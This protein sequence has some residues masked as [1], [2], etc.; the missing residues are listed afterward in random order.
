ML[1]GYFSHGR[2]GFFSFLVTLKDFRKAEMGGKE[3]AVQRDNF[4]QCI[5]GTALGLCRR[6]VG[7]SLENPGGMVQD[8][9]VVGRQGDCLCCVVYGEVAAGVVTVRLQDCVADRLEGQLE[10]GARGCPQ[11][12]GPFPGSAWFLREFVKLEPGLLLQLSLLKWISLRVREAEQDASTA[13]YEKPVPAFLEVNPCSVVN[14][15]VFVSPGVVDNGNAIAPG[16]DFTAC[17]QVQD[18]VAAGI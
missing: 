5:L 9:G 12:L 8:P 11:D 15:K 2:G 3:I 7:G 16:L 10:V 13:F 4:F 1:L 14:R 6:Q 17:H 18:R